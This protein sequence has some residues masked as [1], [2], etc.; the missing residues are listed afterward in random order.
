MSRLRRAEHQSD[1]SS[2]IRLCRRHLFYIQLLFVVPWL[3]TL[4]EPAWCIQANPN[5]LEVVQP[6]GSRVQLRMRGALERWWYEDT[7]GYPVV[8]RNGKY[9]YQ[10]NVNPALIV[11]ELEVGKVD[12]RAQSVRPIRVEQRRLRTVPG[13]R[14]AS[15]DTPRNGRANVAIATPDAIP[16][17]SVPAIGNIRNLVVLMR[18]ANHSGRV[19]PSQSE[20]E[21]LFNAEGGDAVVA[22]TGSVRDL[23][24]ENSYGR[25]TL[26]STVL[27]WFTVQN[28]EQ[29]YADGTSGSRLLW[30]AIVEALNNADDLIDFT[31]FDSNGDGAID[32]ITFIHSGYGAEWGGEDVDGTPPESRI[33]SHK[34]I[35]SPAWI[36]TE[37]VSVS[38]YN[39]NPGL[40]G[41]AGMDIGRIGVIAHELGHIFGLPDLYDTIG[42]GAGVGSWGLMGNSWGFSGTQLNPPHLSA[43]SKI[44]LGWASPTIISTPGFFSLSESERDDDIYRIDTGFLADE[45]LLVEN[46][47]P[48]GFESTM[49]QGGVVVWH[50]D[51]R[52]LGNQ[53]SAYPGSAHWPDAHYKVAVLQ[54]DGNYDL[55]RNANRGDSGDPYVSGDAI[56]STTTPS[57]HAYQRGRLVDTGISLGNFSESASTMSFELSVPPP[58][59]SFTT[60]GGGERWTTNTPVLVSWDTN[61]A[62]TG[63]GYDLDFADSCRAPVNF[64]DDIEGSNTKFTESSNTDSYGWSV[65]VLDAYSGRRHWFATNADRVT[66]QI[67]TTSLAISVPNINPRLSFWHAYDVETEFDGGVVELSTDNVVWIDLG[68]RMLQ[69]GYDRTISACCGNPLSGRSAFTGKSGGYVN[70]LVDLGDYAGQEVLIR[71]RFGTDSIIAGEGWYLDDIS[72][73]GEADVTWT[74]IS[75]GVDSTSYTWVTPQAT[76]DDYCLRLQAVNEHGISPRV[77][78][79]LF[80]MAAA[81]A[82][83]ANIDEPVPGSQFSMNEAAFAWSYNGGPPVDE[84]WLYAGSALGNNDYYNSGALGSLTSDMVTDLPTDGSTVFVRLWYRFG[85][86][87]LVLS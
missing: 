82:S 74:A 68:S 31:D 50:I 26:D 54:A 77:T 76:G 62:P 30:Q 60:P 52:K 20:F 64:F 17:V 55:E 14:G 75:A 4:V 71:F 49:P 9:I 38:T 29:Y 56:D 5:V 7:D 65:D 15:R 45:Y 48:I 28:S 33:W 19:L 59:P 21:T 78:S 73:S 83:G 2:P 67:L 18:F 58:S 86:G 46:R 44:Q 10:T 13:I 84:W 63:T 3:L 37:G 42:D 22:P 66:E 39:I 32:A 57:T 36:A 35:M 80:E 12:P 40:W 16:T 27:D 1:N 23:F 47:Q 87:G 81:N 24:L 41:T 53:E 11:D 34:W 6:D 43:W 85:G 79:E 70:T 8:F 61:G 51:E 69:S 25:F 72:V